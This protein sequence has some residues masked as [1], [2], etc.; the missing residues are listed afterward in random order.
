[1]T[2]KIAIVISVAIHVPF[3]NK[4]LNKS[5]TYDKSFTIPPET[6]EFDLPDGLKFVASESGGD[7][8]LEL[9]EGNW[10]PLY[11]DQ[12]PVGGSVII[13]REILPGVTATGSVELGAD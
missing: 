4:T 3:V 8:H 5:E 12:I 10:L 1:M 9:E 7:I 6:K 2:L 13:N 11:N